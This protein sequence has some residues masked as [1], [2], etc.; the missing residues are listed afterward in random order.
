[1]IP[2]TTPE[3]AVDAI[4]TT[5]KMNA[6]LN[7]LELHHGTVFSKDFSSEIKFKLKSL[8]VLVTESE[9]QLLQ[10]LHSFLMLQKNNLE[11]LIFESLVTFES[12][13]TIVSMPRLKKFRFVDHNTSINSMLQ[14]KIGPQ[15]IPLP[16]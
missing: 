1:M 15:A 13:K 7:T 3:L 9:P 4:R 14:Q 2:Y 10:N 8:K 6:N 12:L 5:L 16:F 11:E